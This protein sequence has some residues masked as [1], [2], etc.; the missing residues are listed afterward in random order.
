[1]IHHTVGDDMHFS[2]YGI[3]GDTRDNVNI[4]WNYRVITHSR[5]SAF[6]V[7]MGYWNIVPVIWTLTITSRL[8]WQSCTYSS[9]S[10]F[11][12]RWAQSCCLILALDDFNTRFILMCND[13]IKPHT[14]YT[15]Y[16]P[17]SVTWNMYV[18]AHVHIHAHIRAALKP[19]L[20]ISNVKHVHVRLACLWRW[21]SNF[22]ILFC[23]TSF[24]L[25][26]LWISFCIAA[27]KKERTSIPRSSAHSTPFVGVLV[28]TKFRAVNIEE[29]Q[30]WSQRA[31]QNE[32]T[33]T[34]ISYSRYGY[35]SLP[36]LHI[37]VCI[38][39]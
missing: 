29:E 37:P 26:C 22:S 24:I 1:M 25:C 38:Y 15:V 33:R 2:P 27:R 23:C 28:I 32:A 11:S 35:V 9:K 5:F 17:T 18:H 31:V 30:M 13:R 21:H 6:L 39:M 4:T 20:S 14:V 3:P 8:K 34:S 10:C 36:E 16:V 7:F 12:F 19:L